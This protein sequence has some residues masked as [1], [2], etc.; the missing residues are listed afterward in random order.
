MLKSICFLLF[1]LVFVSCILAQDRPVFP[2]YSQAIVSR[3][4]PVFDQTIYA[5]IITNDKTEKDG[6]WY[7]SR[8]EQADGK[9][10]EE[11][12]IEYNDD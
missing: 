6:E 4:S 2:I 9:M 3:V 10:K 11:D 5:V 12:V 8:L 7:L 1:P